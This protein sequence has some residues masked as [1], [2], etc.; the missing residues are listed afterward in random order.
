MESVQLTPFVFEKLRPVIDTVR[1]VHITGLGEPFLN[2]H[3][4]DYLSYFRDSGK[5][6]YVNTNGSLIQDVHIDFMTTSKSELSVSLDAG[7]RETYAKVRDATNWERVI[8]RVK[9]VSEI[10][11]ER[12]SPY[13]LLYLTFHI[14]ALNLLSLKKVPELARE[15]GID[16]VK[17]SWT[18]LPE[19]C[20]SHSIFEQRDAVEEIIRGVSMQLHRS[21]IQVASEAVFTDRVRGCWDFSPMTFVG[22]NGA[23]AACCHRWLTIGHL[24]VNSFEDIWNGM[25]RRRIAL[26]IVNGRTEPECKDCSQIKGVDYGRN[27]DDFLKLG[28]LESCILEGKTRTIGKLP[29]LEGLEITFRLGV[30]ALVG[31]EPEAAVGIFSSL[32]DK[33]PDYFEISNNLAVAYHYLGNT[34]KCKALLCS[35]EAIPHNEALTRLNLSRV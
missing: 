4:P 16:A 30:A 23:V 9:R 26:A 32:A 19:T 22:S 10:R 15:L 28:D 31:G 1:H 14:N 25:P 18:M 33:F 12:K 3:L 17:L 20:R 34:E 21:G 29:S 8:S 5:S 27:E 7:D 35:I 2:R 6:Y 24:G 13:P 11:A